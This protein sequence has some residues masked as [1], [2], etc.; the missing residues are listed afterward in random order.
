MGGSAAPHEPGLIAA[1]VLDGR[2]FRCEDVDALLPK[3]SKWR[4]SAEGVSGG[5]NGSSNSAGFRNRIGLRHPSVFCGFRR[6]ASEH[7]AE[8]L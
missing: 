8:T 1:V 7:T 6:N 5:S 4:D 2:F 3:A